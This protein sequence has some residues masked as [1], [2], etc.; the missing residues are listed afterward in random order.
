MGLFSA[1]RKKADST[2]KESNIQAEKRKQSSEEI[3]E[4]EK[5]RLREEEKRRRKE[6]T[7]ISDTYRLRRALS[8]ADSSLST[9]SI[10]FLFPYRQATIF[11]NSV[12][13]DKLGDITKFII[14]KR[15]DKPTFLY[16]YIMSGAVKQQ[17]NR[18][19]SS[20]ELFYF[21]KGKT[22]WGRKGWKRAH[23]CVILSPVFV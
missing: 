4:R 10:D 19:Y 20:N 3:F 18:Y 15:N 6:Q 8:V 16:L 13:I 7:K 11:P 1:F 14:S 21:V 5:A 17:E 12:L 23:S 22:G 2:R 9:T